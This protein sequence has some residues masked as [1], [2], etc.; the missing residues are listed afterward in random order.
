[1]AIEGSLTDVDLADICQLLA[2][3]RKTGCLTVT[4][5]SNFG[6]VYFE[7]GRISYASILNR[8]DRLGELLVRND[9]IT[10]GDLSQAM[11]MQAH[12]P[13]KRLGQILV[14]RGSLTEEEL[15]RYITVQIEEAV[16]H[17]FGWDRGTF[18][19]DPE[20]RPDDG[21]LKVSIHAEGLLLEGARRVDE[22][23]MIEK[24]IPSMDLVFSL[25]RDP[26]GEEDV[27]LT[28]EQR[29]VLPL[30]DGARSV[31]EIGKESGLVE[32]DVAKAVYGL[33]QAGFARRSGQKTEK[34]EEPGDALLHQHLNLGL[35]FYRAGMLEDA[36]RELD[37]ALEIDSTQVEARRTLALI[38]LKSG[39]TE[40]ALEHLVRLAENARVSPGTLRNL[41]FAL[42]LLERYD[43]ALDALARAE[44][45]GVAKEDLDVA[46]AVLNLKRGDPKRSR[47]I[48]RQY[49]KESGTA[50]SPIYYAYALLAEGA[51]GNPEAALAL[52]REGLTRFPEDGA[53]MVNLGVVLE[54]RG[55]TEAAEAL[56]LRAVSGG[57]T[58]P[59]AHK[60][61]GDLA[62]R[63]GDP[64]S[65]RAH[66]ERAI[67]ID[68]KLGDDTYLKL[69]NL[70][71]KEGEREW[72]VG[73]WQRALELNPRNEVV[74]TN[75]E[76]LAA[77]PER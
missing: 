60:N 48:F 40:E 56:Y 24:K 9:V 64:A 12:H 8:P 73:L 13:G 47:D 25:E 21:A 61:L 29:K 10:R 42:E 77:T 46:R 35:A 2:M 23:S 71:Y 26:L 67:R 51:A 41:A 68:P 43:D 11:E 15:T 62:Y 3:G 7:Q 34:A 33:L 14:E 16:Y 30:L 36:E 22:W 20:E 38:G 57:D 53:I 72:A 49:R 69:G 45:S 37:R 28:E 4:D 6:Y 1:M 75:L 74:R 70:A 66:Y 32:F 27:E 39:R 59:Q 19:F 65:A 5:R 17:L 52:G 76:L 58:P 31:E 63:R 55:E 44:T 18:H 50:L 54:R